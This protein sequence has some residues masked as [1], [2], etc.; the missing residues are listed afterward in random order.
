MPDLFECPVLTTNYDE[1]IETVYP[2]RG[3]IPFPILDHTNGYLVGHSTRLRDTPCVFKLHGTVSGRMLDCSTL[4][5]TE[6]QYSE[7]YAE[8]GEVRK[9]LMEFVERRSLFFLGCSLNADRTVEVLK[10]AAGTN[11]IHYAI[12]ECGNTDPDNRVGRLAAAHI[13]TILYENGKHDSVRA[14][15][16]RL[17]DD[18]GLQVLKDP[19]VPIPGP[20]RVSAP[21]AEPTKPATGSLAKLVDRINARLAR[22]QKGHPSFQLMSDS[23]DPSLRPYGMGTEETKAIPSSLRDVK[24]NGAEAMR[25]GDFIR[26]SWEGGQT[27]LFITGRGGVGKT[28]A[29][30]SFA[31]EPGFLPKCVP[32]IYIPLYDLSQYAED[33]IECVDRYLERA[34]SVE[35]RKLIQQISLKPWEGGPNVILLMDGHNEIPAGR[36]DGVERGMRAWA[37]RPG[38]QLV[39]TSRS[40]G[41][42]GVADTSRIEL[43][44]LTREVARGYLERLGTAMPGDADESLW[45]ML[46]TPLM[47]RLY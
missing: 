11:T 23:F 2:G 40:P 47:L 12:A 26:K 18:R 24:P 34:F 42:F 27:H 10:Q 44:G 8:G 20:T 29:L 39:T 35:E 9:A 21:S 6:G 15:L 38:T 4:V 22:Q 1:A 46:E 43:Q 13:R 14:V 32:A 28:V 17:R 37:E 30:L 25:F 19:G 31:T 3:C 45:Q 41:L 33:G 5:L 7:H 16:E 36:R